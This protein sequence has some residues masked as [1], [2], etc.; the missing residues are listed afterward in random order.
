[1][2]FESV[3]NA[4]PVMEGDQESCYY[5]GYAKRDKRSASRYALKTIVCRHKTVKAGSYRVTR[6]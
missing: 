4:S 6:D 3:A 5:N 2:N 1:M